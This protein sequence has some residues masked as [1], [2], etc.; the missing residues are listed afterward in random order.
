MWS[1][2]TVVVCA[3]SLLGR[4][5]QTLPPIALV[6]VRP[7]DVSPQAEGFVRRGS[8]DTIYLITST[9]AFQSAQR[10]RYR[11]GNVQ[12]VIKVASV[13]VHEEWHVR[14]GPDERGAYSAQMMA[15]RSTL[16]VD[17]DRPLFK[18]VRASMNAVLEAQRSRSAA[19]IVAGLSVPRFP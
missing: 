3:L 4:S 9:S 13:I 14:H 11:C 7:A 8:E 16:G 12:A 19:M 5:P 10:A 2:A 1:A 6:E 15:L 18:S 17:P